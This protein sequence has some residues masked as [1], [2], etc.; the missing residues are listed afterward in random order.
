[1]G[2]IICKSNLTEIEGDLCQQKAVAEK[3]QPE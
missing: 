2:S 1:M 3:P